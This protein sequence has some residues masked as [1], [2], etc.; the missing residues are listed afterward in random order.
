MSLQALVS[1]VLPATRP[2][3][4]GYRAVKADAEAAPPSSSAAS[5]PDLSPRHSPRLLPTTPSALARSAALFVLGVLAASVVWGGV[6]SRA[7][8]RAATMQRLE[9]DLEEMWQLR[10]GMNE[11]MGEERRYGP[12][13][14]RPTTW[15]GGFTTP[16][17]REVRSLLPLLPSHLPRRVADFVL[18]SQLLTIDE[19]DNSLYN[20]LRPDLRYLVRLFSP[21]PRT[22]HSL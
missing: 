5:S 1:R 14:R 2:D 19:P 16:G 22:P 20:A 15:R 17:P 7:H 3:D 12:R 4:D 6:L 11:T 9:R 8:E 10:L 21:L 18:F 13:R